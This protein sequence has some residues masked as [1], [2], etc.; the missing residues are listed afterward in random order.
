MEDI[1]GCGAPMIPQRH[2]GTFLPKIDGKKNEFK[3]IDYQYNKHDLDEA[4]NLLRDNG[5]IVHNEFHYLA[6]YKERK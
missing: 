3:K 4:V 5:F 6:F 2:K 1:I